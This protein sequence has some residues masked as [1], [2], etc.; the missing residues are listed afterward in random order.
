MSYYFLNRI[1]RWTMVALFL[2]FVLLP[3]ISHSAPANKKGPENSKPSVTI[4]SPQSGMTYL[5]GSSIHMLAQASDTDGFVEAVSFYHD[6][7]LIASGTKTEGNEWEA[8]WLDVPAGD[9]SLTATA[10]DSLG[11]ETVSAS[12]QVSIKASQNN[13]PMVEIIH[14]LNETLVYEGDTL[15][16]RV[17]AS[18]AEGSINQLELFDGNELL[19]TLEAEPFE[20]SWVVN[21]VGHHALVARA[22]DEQG[23]TVSSHPVLIHVQKQNRYPMVSISWPE[24]CTYYETFNPIYL[25]ADAL[26]IDGEVSKLEF[27]VDGNLIDEDYTPTFSTQ[28]SSL[29]PGIYQVRAQAIDNVGAA[30]LSEPLDL[31]IQLPN[32]QPWINITQP[33][34]NVSIYEGSEILLAADAGDED[35]FVEQVEFYSGNQLIAVLQQSPYEALWTPD[36][37][38]EYAISAKALDDSGAISTSTTLLVTVNELQNEAPQVVLT[39]PLSNAS[40]DASASIQLSAEASD[41]DGQIS[42]VAFYQNN[43]LLF[44]D[45]SAPYDFLWENIAAGSYFLTAKA[46]DDDG[47]LFT[48]EVVTIEVLS[49]QTPIVFLESPLDGE[50]FT[51]SSEI[52]LKAN[53]A[54]PFLDI[55]EVKFFSGSELIAVDESYPY[56][57]MWLPSVAGNHVVSVQAL[58]SSGVS[59][60]SSPATISILD[61]VL[62]LNITSLQ[63]G[64]AVPDNFALIEGKFLAPVNSG[65]M[66]N[67][68]AANIYEDGFYANIPLEAGANTIDVVL[69]T[70]AG[71]S[72]SRSITVHSLAPPSDIEIELAS[73]QVFVPFTNQVKVL[74]HGNWDASIQVNGGN[75]YE[76]PAGETLTLTLSGNNPGVYRYQITAIDTQG[77]F[78]MRNLVFVAIEKSHLDQMLRNNWLAMLNDLGQGDTEAAMAF[79]SEHSK[80][81]YRNALELLAHKMPQIVSSFSD[82]Q[83]SSLNR[84]YAEYG[85]NRIIDGEKHLFFVYYVRDAQGIWRIESL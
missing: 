85:I 54:D 79:F 57:F 32:I 55:V 23:L 49:P 20:F 60:Y 47:T 6:A 8:F 16:V 53:I 37:A 59:A 39:A 64:D 15:S 33:V 21:G 42:S 25:Q 18:D 45:Y 82:L 19:A 36:T 11:A 65:I 1:S 52:L 70:Q 27:Y 29:F 28:W 38:G 84:E 81:R 34:A 56:E 78:V 7:Q 46:R 48:S 77:A 12:V 67:G 71:D 44:E 5:T 75:T 31:H 58:A 80:D 74:N 35:G 73:T 2:I 17:N 69:T 72:I 62:Q 63:D 14:P 9:F 3:P 51:L 40:F 10:R 76:L 50:S 83:T 26:D 13:P 43:V 22:S 41:N 68:Y 24:Q 30:S 66:V 61:T 4:I